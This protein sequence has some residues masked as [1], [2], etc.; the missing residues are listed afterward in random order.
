MENIIST[1]THGVYVLGKDGVLYYKANPRTMPFQAVED[2]ITFHPKRPA[3]FYYN[4]FSVPI[5]LD[6]DKTTLGNRY[7]E[8]RAIAEKNST[9]N[10]LNYLGKIIG[11]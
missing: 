10:F 7:D 4:F 3:S 6:D 5:F 9:F 2:A 8:L 11:I 1:T